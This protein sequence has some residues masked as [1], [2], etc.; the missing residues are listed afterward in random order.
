MLAP[1]VL[2]ALVTCATA[3]FVSAPLPGYDDE[4]QGFVGSLVAADATATTVAVGCPPE[5]P[6]CGLFAAQ[7]FVFGPSTYYLNA[8]DPSSDFTM[9]ADCVITASSAVCKESAGGS[10][11]NFPGSSTETYTEVGTVVIQITAGADKASLPASAA[12]TPSAES[13]MLTGMVTGSASAPLSALPT[14]SRLPS[15]VSQGSGVASASSTSS[16]PAEASTGA[17]SGN[18]VVIGGGLLGAAAGVFGGLLL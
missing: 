8:A 7:T 18:V 14:L 12:A 6:D 13:G 2:S 15:T 1:L 9:T 11:A 16:A 17:A 10:E 4:I 3:Q 5:S